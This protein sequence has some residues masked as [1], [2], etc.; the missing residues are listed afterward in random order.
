MNSTP[1]P[2]GRQRLRLCGRCL[3]CGSTTP[4]LD[5]R[6]NVTPD[7]PPGLATW[8]CGPCA[9]AVPW[10]P[11]L[12]RRIDRLR[13]EYLKRPSALVVIG[14]ATVQ[15]SLPAW[16]ADATVTAFGCPPEHA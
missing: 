2:D 4:G 3:G 11:A 7:T 10:H 15:P 12:Q 6:L 13:P 14:G 5:L 9:D 1:I 16:L 8:L